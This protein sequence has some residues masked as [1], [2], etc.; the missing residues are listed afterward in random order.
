MSGK[1]GS[2]ERAKGT[3]TLA[4]LF[5][6]RARASQQEPI[7]IDVDPEIDVVASGVDADP[8][9]S[10]SAPSEPVAATFA[11]TVVADAPEPQPDEGK[12]RRYRLEQ[13]NP[14]LAYF[15]FKSFRKDTRKIYYSRCLAC[16]A[17]KDDKWVEF[18][19]DTVLKHLGK[20]FDDTGDLVDRKDRYNG[21]LHRKNVK[22]YEECLRTS[23]TRG[24]AS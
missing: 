4:S 18:K 1:R 3:S 8:G 11:T 23:A 15:E 17:G 14:V 13:D 16:D 22:V 24:T 9:P 12:R 2:A 5:S 20:C 7:A 6:K 10:T 21:S 19:S